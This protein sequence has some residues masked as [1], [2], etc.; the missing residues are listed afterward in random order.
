MLHSEPTP[1]GL[2]IIPWL[3]LAAFAALCQALGACAMPLGGMV[4]PDSTGSISTVAAKAATRA[5]FPV[6]L[7]SEDRR[8]ALGALAVALDP[9]G[10]G[11]TVHWDNPVSKAKGSVTPSGFA[12]PANGLICRAFAAQ[13]ETS[14]GVEAGNGA[15]CRDKEA[16]WS[17]SDFHAAKKS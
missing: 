14:A 5:D 12:F 9:Q 16:Q 10:N 4:D 6:S 15:A 7:D 8:R 17:L 1:R 2:Q 11:A 3:R 13:F